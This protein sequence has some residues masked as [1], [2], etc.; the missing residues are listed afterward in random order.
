MQGKDALISE[1]WTNVEG[2]PSGVG[3]TKVYAHHT[4]LDA[5]WDCILAF[6]FNAGKPLMMFRE[7]HGCV[8]NVQ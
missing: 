4:E 5:F 2:A 6:V 8:C 7:K 1:A 3:N